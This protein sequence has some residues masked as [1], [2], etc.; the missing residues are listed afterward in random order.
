MQLAPTDCLLIID[1]QNDFLPGGALAVPDGDQVIPVVNRLAKAFGRV[2][3]TQDWHP[4]EHV[5]FA[6][7]HPGKEPFGTIDLP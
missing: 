3:L 7:N 6:A 5:S 1:V 2:V 4:R